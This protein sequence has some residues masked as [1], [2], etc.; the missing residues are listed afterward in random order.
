MYSEI[1]ILLENT[2]IPFGPKINQYII[3]GPNKGAVAE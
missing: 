3:F 1:T 2:R